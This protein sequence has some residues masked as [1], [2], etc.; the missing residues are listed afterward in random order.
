MKTIRAA[1]N[2]LDGMLGQIER[3][4]LVVDREA[5]RLAPDLERR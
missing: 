3:D 2:E 4:R 1:N 5:Y